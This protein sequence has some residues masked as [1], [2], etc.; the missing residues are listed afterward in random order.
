MSQAASTHNATNSRLLALPSELIGSII[1]D[2]DAVECLSL[3]RACQKLKAEALSSLTRSEF[4]H[5]DIFKAHQRKVGISSNSTELKSPNLRMLVISTYPI[6]HREMTRGLRYFCE[7]RPDMV[8]CHFSPLESGDPVS[9]RP[10][11]MFE[12]LTCGTL[13]LS[14]VGGY[15]CDFST[16][17]EGRSTGW[18]S[19]CTEIVQIVDQRTQY[20]AIGH[21]PVSEGGPKTMLHLEEPGKYNSVRWR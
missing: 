19:R 14:G 5:L 6:M 18:G 1:N 17:K 10:D 2:L 3:A 7:S 9:M 20:L 4:I 15:W 8:H 13:V 11:I 16:P 21:S 12:N